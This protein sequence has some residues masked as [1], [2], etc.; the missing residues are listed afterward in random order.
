MRFETTP[1]SGMWKI[2]V[3]RTKDSRG[4]FG[5]FFVRKNLRVEV[6]YLVFVSG[7]VLVR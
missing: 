1:I 5:R 4:S 3:E 7:A 6:L 2:H